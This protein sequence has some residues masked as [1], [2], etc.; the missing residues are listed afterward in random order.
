MSQKNVRPTRCTHF[1]DPQLDEFRGSLD[2]HEKNK[3]LEGPHPM[4]QS[5]SH[6]DPIDPKEL[7]LDSNTYSLT[8]K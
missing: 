5:A 6:N 7:L 4:H 8:R 3:T 1:F 2:P